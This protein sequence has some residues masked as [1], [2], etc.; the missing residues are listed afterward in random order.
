VAALLARMDDRRALASSA[1]PNR[2]FTL[3]PR[4]RNVREHAFPSGGNGDEKVLTIQLPDAFAAD[5]AD[6]P[7]HPAMLD[8]ALSSARDPKRDGLVLPFM[9]RS[10]VVHGPLPARLYSHIVRRSGTDRLVVADITIVAPDG[11]V[12]VECE[13]F[14]LHAVSSTFRADASGRAAALSRSGQFAPAPGGGRGIEPEAGVSLL[15]DLLRSRPAR[16]VAVRPFQDGRPVPIVRSTGVPVLSPVTVPVPV[17][18]P[19]TVA[20]AAAAWAGAAAPSGPTPAPERAAAGSD[21][22]VVERTRRLWGSV[23][24][25]TDISES[26]DFF[27]LGGNSLAAID[28]VSMVRKEFGVEL[29][30]AMLFDYPTLG[31]LVDALRDRG[32]A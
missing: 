19:Q 3:G 30:V 20:A 32:V 27:D 21:G 10:L 16:Q 1:G 4:W 31:A 28:L 8:T 9:Y 6:Y 23:L 12:V 13:G 18:A 29:N 25:T 24:G 22:T 15:F 11:Q 26:D 17:S 2:L 5:L 14:T 7:L